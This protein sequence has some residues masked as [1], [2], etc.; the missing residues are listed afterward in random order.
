[1]EARLADDPAQPWVSEVTLIEADAPD[2]QSAT[3]VLGRTVPLPW[4][5]DVLAPWAD[6]VAITASATARSR[7]RASRGAPQG[8]QDAMGG[9]HRE[10]S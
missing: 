10:G 2:G 7:R 1:M 9:G 5:L 8:G 6:G 4:N 3:V